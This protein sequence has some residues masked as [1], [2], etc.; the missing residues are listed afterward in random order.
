MATRCTTNG[1]HW[2]R[3]G[4]VTVA[5]SATAFR[6]EARAGFR[7]LCPPRS[8]D[9]KCMSLPPAHRRAT[10]PVTLSMFS[11]R[12][13]IS[14]AMVALISGFS[15][16]FGFARV[17]HGEATSNQDFDVA[18]RAGFIHSI[19][20]DA[21]TGFI[22]GA[23]VLRRLTQDD[24]LRAGTYVQ[25][26]TV[27]EDT[28]WGLHS[29]RTLRGTSPR[30]LPTGTSPT[31]WYHRSMVWVDGRSLH[32]NQLRRTRLRTSLHRPLGR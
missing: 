6:T 2:R 18:V 30:C 5:V 8:L 21:S 22:A 3:Y 4:V 27:G 23:E 29:R 9:K 14:P 7:K 15:C 32:H 25:W 16:T 11:L 19:A 20:W 13:I 26:V 17:V 10:I 28:D 12:S 31:K 24:V 1:Q